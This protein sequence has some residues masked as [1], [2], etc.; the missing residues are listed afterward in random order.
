MGTP[1]E[2]FILFIVVGLL[3]IAIEVFVPG[4]VL[5]VM[6]VFFLLAAVVAGF[7]AFG[8]QG[9]FLAAIAVV[10]AGGIF[11]ALWIKMFPKTGVGKLLTLQSDGKAFKSG[12]PEL[13]ALVDKE[14]VAQTDLRPAGMAVLDGQRRDVVSESGYIA[15]GAKVR[16]ILV[17]G[18]RVVV[19]EIHPS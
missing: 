14:G 17:Q 18:S 13:A 4:G 9:G 19:R 2:L 15:R 7:F 5:G 6:G 10:V 3:L 12:P 16:V 11:L 8:A 1:L